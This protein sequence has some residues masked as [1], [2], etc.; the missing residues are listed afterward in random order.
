VGLSYDGEDEFKT[1]YGAIA[2]LLLSIYIL[3]ALY[4]ALE[5]I[6][7]NKV[8]TSYTQMIKFDPEEKIDLSATKFEFAFGFEKKPINE[9]IVT[10]ELSY[11][12][13]KWNPAKKSRDVQ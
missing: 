4:V 5:S 7:K 6:V 1:Y 13:S 9:E 3:F 8:K 12:T 11:I 2:S 10:F